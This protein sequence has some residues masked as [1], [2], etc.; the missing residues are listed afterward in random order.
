M[1]DGLVQAMN[2]VSLPIQTVVMVY[3]LILLKRHIK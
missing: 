1:F 3:A 2:L